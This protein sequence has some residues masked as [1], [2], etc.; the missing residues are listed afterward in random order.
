MASEDQ[1]QGQSTVTPN[2]LSNIKSALNKLMQ[3]LA[4]DIARRL[5]QEQSSSGNGSAAKSIGGSNDLS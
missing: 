5:K 2:D 1:P 4:K 3:L